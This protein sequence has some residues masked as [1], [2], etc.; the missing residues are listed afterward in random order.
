MSIEKLYLIIFATVLLQMLIINP[1]LK[2]L[3]KIDE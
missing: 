2:K 3:L 1:I